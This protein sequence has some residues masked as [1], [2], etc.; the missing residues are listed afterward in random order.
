RYKN[1]WGAAIN[2]D[3]PM[4]APVREYFLT[5]A[6]YWIE[7]F[8]LDGFR[9]DATQQIF[10]SSEPNIMAVISEE[11]RRRAGKR[12]I[13]LVAEN[14]PQH[15]RLVRPREA[16]GFGMDALWNDD[17]HHAAMV[18]LT[19]RNEA[20]YT[21]YLARPQEFISLVKWGFLFQGQRYKWQKNRR[22]TPALDLPP[23]AFINFIQNH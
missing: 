23:E 12:E 6:V 14:E 5:N 18:A 8:H 11:T 19:S 22:G 3:G 2:F 4:S 20:Y 9:F 16:G 1:E 10:D 13:L 17:F 7:E 15:T 21:D